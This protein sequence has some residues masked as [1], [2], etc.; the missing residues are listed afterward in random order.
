MTDLLRL[1]GEWIQF[2][3]PLRR[4]R[5]F[6]RALYTVCGRWERGP[7]VYPIIPWFCEVDAESVAE[8]LVQTPRIDLTLKDGTALSFALGATVRVKDLRR[9]VNKVD[10]YMESAQ[11]LLAAVAGE[12]IPEVDPDRLQPDKR[13]RLLSDLKRWTQAEADEY[14]I[15]ILK[16]RFTSYVFRPRFYRVLTD[17]GSAAPW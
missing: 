11:E 7:G 5:L 6:E 4:V 9:A 17:A 2:L 1:L 15:E 3:W 10:A 13:G 14:G 8:G 12:K 16:L